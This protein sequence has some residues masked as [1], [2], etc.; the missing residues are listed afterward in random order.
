VTRRERGAEPKDISVAVAITRLDW[1]LDHG[2]LPDGA[3]RARCLVD[4]MRAVIR[5]EARRAPR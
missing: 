3:S 5:E 2:A 1:L 4:L